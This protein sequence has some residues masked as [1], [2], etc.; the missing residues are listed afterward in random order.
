VS[1]DSFNIF[2]VKVMCQNANE[3]RGEAVPTTTEKRGL[4]GLLS[5][6]ERLSSAAMRVRVRA[7]GAR[8]CE[9]APAMR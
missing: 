6:S 4:R 7:E 2:F 9:M 5:N 3:M 8:V 1:A